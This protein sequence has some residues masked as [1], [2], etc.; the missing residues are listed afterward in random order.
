MANDEKLETEQISFRILKKVRSDIDEA[1]K[2]EGIS[3]SDWV[4]NAIEY[5]FINRTNTCPKCHTFNSLDSQYCKKCGEK[6]FNIPQRLVKERSKILMDFT[7]YQIDYSTNKSIFNSNKEFDPVLLRK[8]FVDAQQ[9]IKNWSK[10][11]RFID[12][13]TDYIL[14][15]DIDFE[16]KTELEEQNHFIEEINSIIIPSITKDIIRYKKIIDENKE[17]NEKN[18]LDE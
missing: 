9:L 6:L 12:E 15:Y 17:P 7:L 18:N 1:A 2:A 14:Q 13:N 5:Y 10:N 16:L 8:L 11:K 3:T 4:R